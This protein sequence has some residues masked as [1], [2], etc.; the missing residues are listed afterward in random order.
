MN[1][2]FQIP[3]QLST[4]QLTLIN[5]M[6]YAERMNK[7][8]EQRPNGD[9]IFKF[10]RHCVVQIPLNRRAKNAMDWPVMAS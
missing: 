9:K 6:S 2:G 4:Q 1:S 3:W 7:N 10:Q 8:G 5:E